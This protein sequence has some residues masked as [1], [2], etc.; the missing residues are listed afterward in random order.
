ML[1]NQFIKMRAEHNTE[2]KY[3]AIINHHF[4]N[5]AVP[6]NSGQVGRTIIT[7]TRVPG[8]TNT[9]ASMDDLDTL[10]QKISHLS[11][12]EVYS[13]STR[14]VVGPGLVNLARVIQ[15]TEHE[16]YLHLAFLDGET[17]NVTN[18]LD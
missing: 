1:N 9:V 12:V 3:D 13:T 11:P 6:S 16:K 2:K 14:A 8:A 10:A 4:I 5:F 15:I 7:L 17:L 18:R